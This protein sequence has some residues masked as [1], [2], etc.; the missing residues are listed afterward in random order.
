MAIILAKKF[1]HNSSAIQ[2]IP[3]DRVGYD[4]PVLGTTYKF[5]LSNEG[6]PLTEEILNSTLCFGTDICNV[7][8]R[9]VAELGRDIYGVNI[10]YPDTFSQWP[11]ECKLDRT[12]F[13]KGSELIA[14]SGILGITTGDA[15]NKVNTA[16]TAVG[17]TGAEI[18]TY[19]NACDQELAFNYSGSTEIGSP[20]FC[21]FDE[22]SK[23]SA[24]EIQRITNDS[25]RDVAFVA[26]NYQETACGTYQF[27][28]DLSPQIIPHFQY[29]LWDLSYDGSSFNNEV[30][31]VNGPLVTLSPN[32]TTT[33]A[34]VVVTS[35]ASYHGNTTITVGG[36]VDG[37]TDPT[38][39]NYNSAANNNDG[40]C[41][42]RVVGCTD[43]NATNTHAYATVMCGTSY[44]A[45]SGA[46]GYCCLY[47]G[48]TD[49]VALNYDPSA[50]TDDGSCEYKTAV[51]GCTDT[52]AW[53]YNSN[54]TVNETSASD[55]SNPCVAKNFGCLDPSASNY[56]AEVASGV[57]MHRITDCDY[58]ACTIAA[59]SNTSTGITVSN[60]T[61]TKSGA[62]GG[63]GFFPVYAGSTSPVLI[64]SSGND[65]AGDAIPNLVNNSDLCTFPIAITEPCVA[66]VILDRSVGQVDYNYI[67]NATALTDGTHQLSNVSGKACIDDLTQYSSETWAGTAY[68]KFTG[69]RVKVQVISCNNAILY[70]SQPSTRGE[71]V[72]KTTGLTD[73]AGSPTATSG[74]NTLTDIYTL[75]S[76]EAISA[77]AAAGNWAGTIT[78]SVY[79]YF[80]IKSTVEDP[81]DGLI[82]NTAAGAPISNLIPGDNVA[83]I[84]YHAGYYIP[85]SN[86]TSTF[87]SASTNT[88]IPT[89]Y[90]PGTNAAGEILN[91]SSASCSGTAKDVMYTVYQVEVLDPCVATEIDFSS[92]F[93]CTVIGCTDATTTNPETG[94]TINES[95]YNILNTATNVT[96]SISG[97][98]SA[99]I[100]ASD[101]VAEGGC[102]HL[103]CTDPLY[104]EYDSSATAVTDSTK[105]LNLKVSG[106]TDS[107]ANNYNPLANI[108]QTTTGSILPGDFNNST[109]LAE[110]TYETWAND[111]AQG[112]NGWLFGGNPLPF[113]VVEGG[114]EKVVGQG[115]LRYLSIP[116]NIN[117]TYTVSFKITHISG[118]KDFSLDF[119][120][121]N[122]STITPAGTNITSV[123]SGTATTFTQTGVTFND[124][125]V[126]IN[127]I[128]AAD[129][130]CYIHFI[131]LV[132]NNA[133]VD[134]CDYSL[135]LPPVYD[136]CSYTVNA[137]GTTV[138]GIFENVYN[139]DFAAYQAAFPVL[140]NLET[141][142]TPT[143][144]TS[145]Y[146]LG[147]FNDGGN[148]LEDSFTVF[149]T[150]A[151]LVGNVNI[152]HNRQT[153]YTAEKVNVINTTNSILTFN[154]TTAQVNYTIDNFKLNNVSK[155]GALKNVHPVGVES[156]LDYLEQNGYTAE[157][158]RNEIFNV[159]FDKSI[160][161]KLNPLRCDIPG[162]CAND[163][164]WTNEKAYTFDEIWYILEDT[165]AGLEGR[166][167]IKDPNGDVFMPEFQFNGI[168]PS[169]GFTS[170]FLTSPNRY[171]FIPEPGSAEAVQYPDG[172]M[173]S[174]MTGCNSSYKIPSYTV[175]SFYPNKRLLNK[176]SA[177]TLN[178][179]AYIET[180]P[181]IV[182]FGCMDP[183][184]ANYDAN[185]QA[186][187]AGYLNNSECVY[188]V[189][190]GPGVGPTIE[191]E[192]PLPSGCSHDYVVS[193]TGSNDGPY[194]NSV[195]AQIDI[196]LSQT[197]SSVDGTQGTQELGVIESWEACEEGFESDDE[198]TYFTLPISYN[199][200]DTTSL[201]VITELVPSGDFAIAGANWLNENNEAEFCVTI[202]QSYPTLVYT[203][204]NGVEQTGLSLT[205]EKCFF[206]PQVVYGC[207]T[208]GQF[209]YDSD[210]TCIIT[211]GLDGECYPVIP[212]CLNE[213]AFNSNN[214]A[215][216]TAGGVGNPL[217]VV[218]STFTNNYLTDV[219]TDNGTCIPSITGCMTQSAVNYNHALVAGVDVNYNDGYTT[220]SHN[221]PIN[222]NISDSTY[223]YF[224]NGIPNITSITESFNTTPDAAGTENDVMYSFSTNGDFDADNAAV[225]S[226]TPYVITFNYIATTAIGTANP[227]ILTV[228]SSEVSEF[229]THFYLDNSSN[230]APYFL[231]AGAQSLYSWS[232]TFSYNWGELNNEAEDIANRCIGDNNQTI[233]H[234]ISLSGAPE[235]VSGCTDAT[236]FN[237]NPNATNDD[238]NTCIDIV[239]GCN[240]ETAANYNNYN[241]GNI[242]ETSAGTGTDVNTQITPT[243]DP[244]NYTDFQCQFVGCTDSSADNYN[245]NATTGDLNAGDSTSDTSPNYCKFSGCT[246]SSADNYQSY[247][248]VDD[249]SCQ[250]SGCTD[251]T[252]T[253]YDAS[254]NVDDGSC[255]L[256][257]C[258]DHGLWP[259]VSTG[260]LS[261]V[262]NTVL[263]S[264]NSQNI[265]SPFPG[266]AAD[267]YNSSATQHTKTCLYTGCT[268]PTAINYDTGYTAA[269]NSTCI[270]PGCMNSSNPV[271]VGSDLDLTGQYTNYNA[272]ANS[273]NCKGPNQSLSGQMTIA[274]LPYGSQPIT[275]L[276]SAQ[277]G[278]WIP[279]VSGKYTISPDT[280]EGYATGVKITALTGATITTN[281]INVSIPITE[282]T[283]ITTGPQ[284]SAI[285]GTK[286][287]PNTSYI[288]TFSATVTQ[289]A[290]VFFEITS[291]ASPAIMGSSAPNFVDAESTYSIDYTALSLTNPGGANIN[292]IP[293]PGISIP[294]N[295]SSG[296]VVTPVQ[297]ESS[298]TSVAA[299]QNTLSTYTINFKTGVSHTDRLVNFTVRGLLATHS[300]IIHEITSIVQNLCPDV[301]SDSA[302]DSIKCYLHG[303]GIDGLYPPGHADA[304]LP[305][306][307]NYSDLVTY[308]LEAG[309][310]G[311]NGEQGCKRGGCMN[312]YADNYDL[313]ATFDDGSCTIDICTD[314]ALTINNENAENYLISD[315]DNTNLSVGT[316]VD[317]NHLDYTGILFNDSGCV[318]LGCTNEA[319]FNYDE[320]ATT[321]TTLNPVHTT[322]CDAIVEGCTDVQAYNYND[323]NDDGI[324]NDP[325]VN[326]DDGTCCANLYYEINGVGKYNVLGTGSQGSDLLSTTRYT[327]VHYSSLG[328]NTVTDTA[329]Q[330]VI[331]A[332][333]AGVNAGGLIYPLAEIND[334]NPNNLY[335]INAVGLETNN[336][337]NLSATNVYT[338]GEDNA[339]FLLKK[340]DGS[341][342]TIIET[343]AYAA[344]QNINIDFEYNATHQYYFEW[345]NIS[346]NAIITFSNFEIKKHTA[347]YPLISQLNCTGVAT[348]DVAFDPLYDIDPITS[349]GGSGATS[350]TITTH[351]PTSAGSPTADYN[352]TIFTY[353]NVSWGQLDQANR[354]E[355]IN[356]TAYAAGSWTAESSNSVIT[357]PTATSVKVTA[358]SGAGDT[359]MYAMLNTAGIAEDL[360][361]GGGLNHMNTGYLDN[362]NSGQTT[363]YT[364]EFILTTDDSNVEVDVTDGTNVLATSTAG[365]SSSVRRMLFS[366]PTGKEDDIRIQFDSL[367]ENKYAEISAISLKRSF[368]LG[369]YDTANSSKGVASF[370]KI[371]FTYPNESGTLA[372]C[373]Y[374][375]TI[376]VSG[377][378]Q[379]TYGC[380]DNGLEPNGAQLIN[381]IGSDGL[382]AFNY[383]N[384]ANINATSASD[385]TDPC[386]AKVF[387]CTDS[388]AFNYDSSANVNQHSE[389]NTTS[390]CYPKVF[391]CTD[392]ASH[393]YNNYWNNNVG[394]GDTFNQ[395]FHN[396][397]DGAPWVS[398][399]SLG[400]EYTAADKFSMQEPLRGE[401]PNP[402]TMVHQLEN[403]ITGP[404]GFVYTTTT[405]PAGFGD[406][407]QP[408]TGVRGIDV[409]TSISSGPG[410]CVSI[411]R[412]CMDSTATNYNSAANQEFS[413]SNCCYDLDVAD[414]YLGPLPIV[415]EEVCEAK[416][417][418]YADS[419]AYSGNILVNVKL[420]TAPIHEDIQ[421]ASAV[422]TITSK[423]RADTV[424][425]TVTTSYAA[426]KPGQPGINIKT[427]KYALDSQATLESAYL[428]NNT[429]NSAFPTSH[430][431]NDDNRASKITVS[432]S[433]ES[434]YEASPSGS[435]AN[436]GFNPCTLASQDVSLLPSIGTVI[437]GGIVYKTDATNDHVYIASLDSV[438]N[439]KWGCVGTNVSGAT[440]TAIGGG[441]ANTTAIEAACT[442]A[443]TAADRVTNLVQDTFTD[444]YLPS[445]G[446]LEEIYTNL[447]ATGLVTSLEGQ[448]WSSTQV[449]AN[450]A[451][452]ISL[453]D[454]TNRDVSKT[455][456]AK[457]LAVRRVNGTHIGSNPACKSLY[458]CTDPNFLEYYAT[459]TLNADSAGALI[460]N[461]TCTTPAIIGCANSNYAEHY[462]DT[463]TE[464][465]NQGVSS[466]PF[467][468]PVV[469]YTSYSGT[470]INVNDPTACTNVL[471]PGCTD[472]T[473]TNAY[474][475][476]VGTGAD[477]QA[478]FGNAGVPAGISL[479]YTNKY[480]VS[481]TESFDYY[482]ASNGACG[483]PAVFG[484]TTKF[485]DSITYTDI[486]TDVDVTITPSHC[487]YTST[488]NIVNNS[489][490]TS[491]Y[492]CTDENYSEYTY[493]DA[494]CN[495]T[496]S[497]DNAGVVCKNELI[498]ACTD[499]NYLEGIVN[500][501]AVSTPSMCLTPKVSGCT[502]T[503]Y[504]EHYLSFNETGQINNFD[505]LPGTNTTGDT[506]LNNGSCI[507]LI[508][509]TNTDYIDAYNSNSYGTI[510]GDGVAIEN[511]G[512]GY[513]LGQ[514][515]YTGIN[516]ATPAFTYSLFSASNGTY[517]NINSGCQG[518]LLISGCALTNSTNY[519]ANANIPCTPALSNNECC[520]ESIPGCTDAA[521]SNFDPTATD[522]DGSCSPHI[523][524]CTNPESPSYNAQATAGNPTATSACIENIYGCIESTVIGLDN[525]STASYPCVEPGSNTPGCYQQGYAPGNGVPITA[526][527]TDFSDPTYK[528]DLNC[529]PLIVGC[530]DA[531]ALNFNQTETAIN[532]SATILPAIPL[533][534]SINAL[535][536][537]V[538]SACT[539][540]CEASINGCTDSTANNYNSLATVDDG[541]C[542][543]VS[544]CM[545]EAAWNYS[546]TATLNDGTCEFCQQF[547]VTHIIT[548]PTKADSTD[549]I[550]ELS[551][552][553]NIGYNITWTV[554][555]LPDSDYDGL[556]VLTGLSADIDYSYTIYDTVNTS[557]GVSAT[558][559][560]L[561][562]NTTTDTIVLSPDD[563]GCTDSTAPNF[564][565]DAS[566]DDGSCIINGCTDST[567]TNYN[568]AANTNDGSCVYALG[569]TDLTACNYNTDAVSDDGTCIYPVGH[570]NCD[571]LCNNPVDADLYPHLAGYC[572]EDVSEGCV[573][574]N[575][576]NFTGR[577]VTSRL[578][579]NP[580]SPSQIAA[581][582]IAVKD[583]G[584]CVYL[585]ECVPKDIYSIQDALKKTISDLSKT[586]YTQMRTGMLDGVDMEILWKLQLID[587]TL[588]RTGNASLFNCQDY[589]HLGKVTY[590]EGVVDSLNY[591]DRFLT[592]AFKH[593]DQHFVQVQNARIAKLKVSKF[594]NN[595]NKKRN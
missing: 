40:S 439:S 330:F 245:P 315:S 18:F 46:E 166:F 143:D 277:P 578:N 425:D 65:P 312:Q 443:N 392:S 291:P 414:T 413:P 239:Y 492:G 106:C 54:A 539:N 404:S 119:L 172:Y 112:Y 225:D 57:N 549:G 580:E 99:T 564:D 480:G 504:A 339:T 176:C 2:V 279:G 26:I 95:N 224:C 171:S 447:K 141:L 486:E 252:A 545:S 435:T 205:T 342:T 187:T 489:L 110:D 145:N 253:N 587:Y 548:K 34:F 412:G 100:A 102:Y 475:P 493:Y 535:F 115:Q 360:I 538:N 327:K 428:N 16:T 251:S 198:G 490:C 420:G 8:I 450:T 111:T 188:F 361:A 234:V 162:S 566:I 190:G 272:N 347:V 24:Q 233:T 125:Q 122:G 212:G 80:V 58:E 345:A 591:L 69:E 322:S 32:T 258:M 353:S 558:F 554:G 73:P 6:Q 314:P 444:W 154:S 17:Y 464:I 244:S 173:Y 21:Q 93:S 402:S 259:E 265:S 74:G 249:G 467:N 461:G 223:C 394:T 55:S 561:A 217:A 83:K 184:A 518:D 482:N 332:P 194:S 61:N 551:I 485:S 231:N 5:A 377:T 336:I 519:V 226:T 175:L 508:G 137:S 363:C 268:D 256:N 51:Y 406:Y 114:L 593:G 567:A 326:T 250:F 516:N 306:A 358:G 472:F 463:T 296:L 39:D 398:G 208:E 213:N 584:T 97:L 522:D 31:G 27:W 201:G 240:N 49:P 582:P 261:G 214:G 585:N 299:N 563:F 4:A 380:T 127:V 158:T 282:D 113:N 222:V 165:I 3:S 202:T 10:I 588:N 9:V 227:T 236:A 468:Y 456:E 71:V 541:T 470:S 426:L 81:I 248:N 491:V 328:A 465:L 286:L 301:T 348:V 147:V 583:D 160:R 232:V 479:T 411:V 317:P 211:P 164:V 416:P 515:L 341:T 298:V 130:V 284:I 433:Y 316:V 283:T 422:Y 371:T 266:T 517:G 462:D 305:W 56:S 393:N 14:D 311:P 478:L 242:S 378:C 246:D 168:A 441:L 381:D 197:Y 215:L 174:D 384:L 178:I 553:P 13:T 524:G 33:I 167:T 533:D 334:G 140:P 309:E 544:G 293:L 60:F 466:N 180:A 576:L 423:N 260:S 72:Y 7:R 509:C 556:T 513:T 169:P 29:I 177:D 52:G 570:Y 310:T 471:V 47:N 103:A 87:Q 559:C 434:P 520:Y 457:V 136:L 43:S 510:T 230:T 319:S 523:A 20:E 135:D 185:A 424:I 200:V 440:S 547:D 292:T 191:I 237:Y 484:C 429:A 195:Q 278:G 193:F 458:G 63:Y 123:V 514:T 442:T 445:T 595:R 373:T 386:V 218:G 155:A 427:Y 432:V 129:A 15:Q 42:Y 495:A 12:I 333:S 496:A 157:I 62:N 483:N 340:S 430:T 37:C 526:P 335:G 228:R 229:Y 53:N 25:N 369:I 161:L 108:N 391:G 204:S 243:N 530:T 107:N 569:C 304:G 308:S 449:D 557:S 181:S 324:A 374:T 531:T 295:I 75:E 367:S 438:A 577:T 82:L 118:S 379:Q 219:N 98:T 389:T 307:T 70:L 281:E 78:S 329:T 500:P 323:T 487:A 552:D 579:I 19:A 121:G 85:S 320:Q 532:A 138:P 288:I 210:S 11:S 542:T 64:S 254:A 525:V 407:P 257:G 1:D 68:K 48:C 199:P 86:N 498:L 94:L 365:V 473:K 88:D 285:G 419:G 560:Q 23:L 527:N 349:L 247:Y 494:G 390:P 318:W 477:G 501:F 586:V 506:S 170:N 415:T 387:G 594:K 206:I 35:Y 421:A 262:A 476:T 313:F 395:N 116:V 446:E 89:G 474:G 448:Y 216:A 410:S 521:A 581:I 488:T 359:G 275:W 263:N 362:D 454:K 528:G 436:A 452:T 182:N 403:S 366:V 300:V 146:S 368:P 376:V 497:S 350:M 41:Q 196:T 571:G 290:D 388:T 418:V 148:C 159:R 274:D 38:A 343:I 352:T 207:T 431:G 459:P 499:M 255:F 92:M 134:P 151:D 572:E 568:A 356:S 574:V 375:Q 562:A 124:A 101:Y 351:P 505:P 302:D 271:I 437:D 453:T 354:S 303:C 50:T 383:N 59:A 405:A 149:Q 325:A 397:I 267:N 469:L 77:A 512:N 502:D 270:Y 192:E 67:Y 44:D 590:S 400:T 355:L 133:L 344:T 346:N 337:Y 399:S 84:T 529:Y 142:L 555:G 455:T 131:E 575:A 144:V 104:T 396:V 203:D 189:V 105:C 269:D 45:A 139:S 382:A 294:F 30:S 321:D 543:Y 238:G 156:L 22:L 417:Y 241:E 273:N 28:I 372:G 152:N 209:N 408:L 96:S 507:N 451:K 280:T 592:F 235:Y 385:A 481:V 540:C 109:G 537:N 364:L 163:E 565:A 331:T 126:Q 120:L 287:H 36:C 76:A 573:D 357:T 90:R 550:I 91:N 79:Y 66:P 511:G 117:S 338:G 536:I 289:A 264:H 276:G 186:N 409:N 221:L 460:D 297:A 183:A 220:A 546:S 534:T 589:S 150:V 370:V 132:P 153:P 128:T 179:A 401:D 503:A